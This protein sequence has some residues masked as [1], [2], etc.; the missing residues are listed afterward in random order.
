[1]KR[2]KSTDFYLPPEMWFEIMKFLRWSSAITMKK[3][4]KMMVH[5]YLT[6]Y[7]PYKMK[8][9]VEGKKRLVEGLLSLT[10]EEFPDDQK[11][12]DDCQCPLLDQFVKNTRSTINVQEFDQET[13]YDFCVGD[14][15]PIPCCE[16][17]FVK[18][19]N[20]IR[21]EQLYSPDIYAFKHFYK[22]LKREVSDEQYKETCTIC[23]K[24][25]CKRPVINM[26]V[27][28]GIFYTDLYYNEEGEEEGSLLHILTNCGMYN[29]TRGWV[30]RDC[31]NE[32]SLFGRKLK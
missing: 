11:W 15:T 3:V 24:K 25:F 8:R 1:M 12:T 10:D 2:V 13:H 31:I 28:D 30:C 19:R 32:N 23:S 6:M 27:D 4:S 20:Y 26:E 14:F 17:G 22:E 7:F 5:V 29:E 21:D 18:I 16:V 9:L